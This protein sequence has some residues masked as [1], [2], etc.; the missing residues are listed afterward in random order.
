M[1]R[2]AAL[3]L[4]RMIRLGIRVLSLV[5]VAWSPD[6]G[7]LALTLRDENVCPWYCDTAIGVINA[8]GTQLRLLD[9]AQ[10]SEDVYLWAPAW[11]PDGARLAYT[12][13]RGDECTY[14][15]VPCGSDIAVVG[16]DG[17][18]IELLISAGGFPSWRQ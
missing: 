6:A 3:N 15:R 10:T 2:P 9:K 5:L 17:G 14:D 18:P 8:D 4:K 7:R 11:A 1:A 12:V 16:V 13:T